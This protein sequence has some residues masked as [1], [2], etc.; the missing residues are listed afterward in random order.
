MYNA[1]KINKKVIDMQNK[2]Q[3]GIKKETLN[4]KKSRLSLFNQRSLIL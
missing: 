1:I 2:A 4:I 3:L